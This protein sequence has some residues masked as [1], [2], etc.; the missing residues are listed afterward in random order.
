[1][2]CS[3]IIDHEELEQ[4]LDERKDLMTEWPEVG[5]VEIHN[6]VLSKAGRVTSH[7]G[8]PDCCRA[9]KESQ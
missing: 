5:L 4:K 9:A 7:L 2:R 6:G 3:E 1:M 8:F